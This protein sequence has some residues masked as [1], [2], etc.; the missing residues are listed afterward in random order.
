M[1]LP[2]PFVIRESTHRIHDPLT[3]AKLARL[4]EALLLRPGQQ[5]LDLACGSGEMLCTWARDHGITGLGVDLSSAFIDVARARP[6]ELGVAD[7]VRFEH[8]DAADGSVHLAACLGATWIG[9]GIIGTADLPARSLRGGGLML[10]GEPYWVR[11]PATDN[12]ARACHA[13]QQRVV[14]AARAAVLISEPR[15]RPGAD[16]ACQPRRLG[17]LPRAAVVEP[18]PAAR[19]EP[20]RRTAA[21][22]ACRTGLRARRPSGYPRTSRLGRLCAHAPMRKRP[23]SRGP[24]VRRSAR[25]RMLG[26]QDGPVSCPSPLRIP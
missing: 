9:D 1:D 15:P 22:T 19:R 5:V 14:D 24:M 18:S 3:P 11:V 13:R 6:V 25:M 23:Q 12:L 10:I 16:A 20:R 26:R 17:R 2:G 7:R 8:D 4:G 21:P